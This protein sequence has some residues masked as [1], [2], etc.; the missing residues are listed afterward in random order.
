[1]VASGPVSRLTTPPGHVGGGQHL[2]EGDGRQRPVGRGGDDHAVLPVTITGATTQTRPSRTTPA[3]ASTATTPVGSG[4][5]RLKNGP[6]TG[7]ALPTTWVTLS[8]QPAYQTSGRSRRRPPCRP[9]AAVSAL[10]LARRPRRTAGGGP[11]SPRR[12]G[13]GPARG[14]TPSRRTSPGTPC[15]PRRRRR[16]RPCARPSAALARKRP[17][18]VVHDVGAARLRARERPRRRRACRSCAR[19]PA[20][21]RLCPCR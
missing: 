8:A 9:A 13:R 10:G 1:M 6:A 12:P 18:G 3:G 4:V 20:H 7:L 19:R 16:G 11:P 21:R 14:C 5:E 17:R 15:G 2:G